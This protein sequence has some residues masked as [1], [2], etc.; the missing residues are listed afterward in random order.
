MLTIPDAVREAFGG[1][2]SLLLPAWCA[3]CDAPDAVLCA[4]CRAALAA[5][6]RAGRPPRT[7]SSGIRVHAAVEFSGIPARVIRA[8]K[9]EGRT[10]LARPLGTAL[11]VAVGAALTSA[12]AG[13]DVVVV[14]VPS[15]RA[16]FRRRGHHVAELIARRGGLEV[17]RLLRVDAATADQRLLGRGE[18]AANVAGSMRARGAPGV[19]V[20]VVDDVV[21]TGA[22]LREAARAL[23]AAGAT[24]RGA[25]AVA[26][27]SRVWRE[28]G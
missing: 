14:P 8:F 18:R 3:G 16:A 4:D 7:L 6:V 12:S 2:L 21:T 20:I 24:V 11:A 5:A 13:D 19:Q 10:G 23:E 27:T 28:G 17:A 9:E 15:S 1:A 22:T 25:A 26:S